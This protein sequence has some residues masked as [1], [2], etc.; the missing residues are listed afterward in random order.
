MQR[1]T[2]LPASVESSK[3]RP[4]EVSFFFSRISTAHALL[5]SF[6]HT[7][8]ILVRKDCYVAVTGLPEAQEDHAVRMAKF[9][10]QCLTQ[11][12]PV[13]HSLAEKLGPETTDLSMRFGL[14]SGPVTAG[15]LR[16]EK[17]RFQLFGDTVN[18][19]MY[20]LAM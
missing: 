6:A 17:A 18:T 10:A 4:L 13:L 11:V 12:G 8:A 19:G 15:V 16:G 7:W 1:S 2:R 9:A 20:K 14:N 3:W 5:F